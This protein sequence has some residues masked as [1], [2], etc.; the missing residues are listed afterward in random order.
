M[1][2]FIKIFAIFVLKEVIEWT[3]VVIKCH[4][5]AFIMKMKFGKMTLN[6]KCKE[7]FSEK[8]WK[9]LKKFVKLY[10]KS[11]KFKI[12]LTNYFVEDYLNGGKKSYID[13]N[14]MIKVA[15]DWP[16]WIK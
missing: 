4:P 13:T 14:F 1:T 10:N 15:D 12:F 3:Y 6:D 8:E 7:E 5:V 2:L 11:R 9:N 16:F